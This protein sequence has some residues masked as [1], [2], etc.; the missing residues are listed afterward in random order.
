MFRGL[1]DQPNADHC[2][3]RMEKRL[4][5]DTRIKNAKT[6]LEK[7]TRRRIGEGVVGKA[8]EETEEAAVA[9][10]DDERLRSRSTGRSTSIGRRPKWTRVTR[11]GGS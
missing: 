3:R 7:R 2:R 10:Q 6:R 5:E 9:E 1:H 11:R 8:F 4:A